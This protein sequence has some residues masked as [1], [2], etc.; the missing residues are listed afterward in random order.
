MEA[1]KTYYLTLEQY[2]KIIV[3]GHALPPLKKDP[4]FED[5]N[6]GE[7]EIGCC[8]RV[9]FDRSIN[10]PRLEVIKRCASEKDVIYG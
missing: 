4:N 8:V 1:G 2:S 3:D 5:K 6:P 9:V 10:M 7:K